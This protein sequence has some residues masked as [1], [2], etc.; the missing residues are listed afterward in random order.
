[1]NQVVG[2]AEMKVSRAPGDVIVTYSLGSCIGVTMYDPRVRVGGLIH[3][4]LPFSTI[5][6][7]KAKAKPEMFTDT[8]VAALLSALF[9]MGAEKK[10]LIVKVAGASKLL[11]SNGVFKIG[12]RNVV[13]LK[14]VLEK[15][16]IPIA[17]EDVGGTVARTMFLYMGTG[18]TV[19]KV[20]GKEFEL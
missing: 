15:N 9:E 6:P 1:M 4:M 19:L 5:D 13:V 7:A 12:E 10:N 18:Q 14:K 8:G 16:A 2:V 3:C 17:A 11:D 20:S